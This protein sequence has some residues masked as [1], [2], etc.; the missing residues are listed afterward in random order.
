MVWSKKKI[1]N[2]PAGGAA[3]LELFFSRALRRRAVGSGKLHFFSYP[4]F[5]ARLSIVQTCK[6]KKMDYCHCFQTLRVVGAVNYVPVAVVDTVL[7]VERTV[8]VFVYHG[9]HHALH[10]V[11]TLHVVGQQRRSHLGHETVRQVST[12]NGHAGVDR[13]VYR[14]GRG[15][16]HIVE[17]I[18]TQKLLAILI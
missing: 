13:R 11:V 14:V 18:I 12:V 7:V 10:V 1:R 5:A 17:K 3:V 4:I 16:F 2:F 9:R 6:I 8:L 15:Y